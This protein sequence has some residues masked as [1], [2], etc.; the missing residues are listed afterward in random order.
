MSFKGRFRHLD[1]YGQPILQERRAIPGSGQDKNRSNRIKLNVSYKETVRM[2]EKMSEMEIDDKEM[3]KPEPRD[4]YN[5][6]FSLDEKFPKVKMEP[7]EE[8]L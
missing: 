3:I 8:E 2:A 6:M 1:P 5:G 7:I 4:D